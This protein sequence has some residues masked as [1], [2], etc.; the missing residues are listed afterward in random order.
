VGSSASGITGFLVLRDGV[1]V[2]GNYTL[3]PVPG[4]LTVTAAPTVP[5][6]PPA[7]AVPEETIPETDTPLA[8]PPAPP[9]TSTPTPSDNGGTTIEEPSTPE[10]I[11]E[12][13]PEP[14]PVGHW[15]LLNL[16]LALAAVIFA[17]ALLI[18]LVTGRRKDEDGHGNTTKG[19]SGNLW[20]VLGIVLGVVSP[21]VFFLTENIMRPMVIFDIWTLLMAAFVL[22]QVVFVLVMWRVRKPGKGDTDGRASATA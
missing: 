14:E 1:D 9:N 15:A 17:F 8:E 3:V 10:T 16:L 20:R 19:R 12:P 6:V 4:T 22:F 13:E 5:V 18:H 21:I 11:I 7:P 2:T